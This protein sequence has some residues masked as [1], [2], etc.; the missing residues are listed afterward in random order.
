MRGIVDGQ[1]TR[2]DEMS[3]MSQRGGTGQTDER[4]RR[5]GSRQGIVL[6]QLYVY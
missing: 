6:K 5:G 1:T 2:A 3:F 4:V